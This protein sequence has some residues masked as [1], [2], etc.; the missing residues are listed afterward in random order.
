MF[1]TTSLCANTSRETCCASLDGAA[2]HDSTNRSSGT[3]FYRFGEVNHDD[4]IG[5]RAL[6]Y[7][8]ADNQID[9]LSKAFQATTVACARCHDHKIDAVSMKDYYA[10]LGILRSA[11]QV[12]HTID[13]PDVNATKIERLRG[14]KQDLRQELADTWLRDA[15]EMGRFMLAVAARRGD[16]PEAA[17]LAQGLDPQRLEKWGAVLQ[18]EKAPLEDPLEPWREIAKAPVSAESNLAAEWHT[19]ADRYAKEDRDREDRNSKEYVTFADF[20]EHG[21]AEWQVD[22]L[23]ARASSGRSGDFVVHPDGDALVS[24][25][26]PAGCFTHSLSDKLNGTLRS[27]VLPTGKKQISLEVMGQR[28]SAVRLVSNNCQLNYKN[29]RALTSSELQWVTFSPPDDRDSLRTYAELMTMFDNPKFPDQLSALGGDKNNYKLPWDEAAANPRSYFGVT[30]AVLHDCPEPPKPALNFLRPL[31]A[32][33]DLRSLTEVVGR[34]VAITQSALRAWGMDQASDDEVRWLQALLRHGLLE[35]R[36]NGTPRLQ[37]LAEQ[38]RQT[39]SEISLPRVTP[40][41]ADFGPGSDQPLFVRGDCFRPD[42]AVPRRYLE[43]LSKPGAAFSSA[44]SG[45]LELAAQ[46]AAADNPFTARVMVNRIWHH[47]FGTGIVKTV[48]DFG[49]VGELPSHAELLD[50]LAAEF[51]E[52]GWSVKRLVRT[53]VLTRTFGL[54]NQPSLAAKAI[55]PQDRLLQHY[56]ARRMEAESIRDSILAVSGR[57][58]EKLYG[59]SIQPYRDV[60]NADRRLFPGPLD[61]NGRR[62]IYIKN[63]LMEAPEFLGA[64]NFPGGKVAQ[65]RRDVTNVPAQALALLNDAFVLQQSEAWADRLIAREGDSLATRVDALFQT[66]LLRAPTEMERA[67]FEQAATQFAELHEVAAPEI[68]QSRAVWIDLAHATFNLKEFIYIP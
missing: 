4:C 40:G 15:G 33:A 56:P 1:P 21:G 2:N 31:F 10:L 65:G 68:L 17:D 38:F 36:I 57:L 45:R 63:N 5:L 30:R 6:G 52:Q 64:F 48:D 37:S 42:E 47:L 26:L 46:I 34:Y 23:G 13:A 41:L 14:I 39:E 59:M 54:S 8:L 3:A 55:D 58:D 53:L 35:N 9:T 18:V 24:A 67:S 60:K 28:S 32:G 7:D 29:Y 44:G 12:S 19:I 66:A 51:V 25:L 50:Y 43:V 22:G 11:R 16:R 20:G 49:H 27:G 62:S 61:G